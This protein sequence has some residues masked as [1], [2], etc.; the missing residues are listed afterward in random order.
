MG[1][2]GN[3][4]ADPHTRV[5]NVLSTK[6]SP[7]QPL[8][9]LLYLCCVFMWTQLHGCRSAHIRRTEKTLGVILSRVPLPLRKNLTG[10]LGQSSRG[11]PVPAPWYWITSMYWAV[12]ISLEEPNSG[13]HAYK[14]NALLSEP[15]SY[16]SLPGYSFLV[17]LLAQYIFD[18]CVRNWTALS[19]ETRGLTSHFL[20]L[21]F[22][23]PQREWV[24][25]WLSICRTVQALFL[26]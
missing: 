2:S 8:V 19:S 23:S 18:V 10:L 7:N 5:A 17:H 11:P 15:F 21:T 13:P 12:L 1:C 3:L 9:Y 25:L 16:S 22:W 24:S 6:P 14:T 4:N 26:H 20:F